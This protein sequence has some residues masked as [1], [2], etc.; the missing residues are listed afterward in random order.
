MK[1]KNLVQHTIKAVYLKVS[2]FY[3]DFRSLN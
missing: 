2:S 3:I 1:S